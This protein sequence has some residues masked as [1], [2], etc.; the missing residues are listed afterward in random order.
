[1]KTAKI[2]RHRHTYHHYINDHL[3][4]VEDDVQF[5][6]V[7]SDPADMIAWK[8]WCKQ[9]G[10]EYEYNKEEN[11]QT[12]KTPELKI[13]K[14]VDDPCFCDYM[15]YYLLHIAGFE[16]HSTIEPYKGEIYIHS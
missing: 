16:F 10:G 8:Q 2:V 14:D 7:F 6:I 5:K 3:I 4:S 9:N 1:M 11:K 15:S 12:G 13:F